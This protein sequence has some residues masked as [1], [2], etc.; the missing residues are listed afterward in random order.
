MNSRRTDYTKEEGK[1]IDRSGL[2]EIGKPSEG[3]NEGRT[4]LEGLTGRR[5]NGQGEANG[6]PQQQNSPEGLGLRQR[7]VGGK[8]ENRNSIN[9]EEG[10]EEGQEDI[11][12]VEDFDQMGD[13]TQ[14]G[15]KGLDWSDF[16]VDFHS[17][18]PSI[19]AKE[20]QRVAKNNATKLI[21][22]RPYMIPRPFT[23][24]E[25]DSIQKCLDLFRLMN[26]RHMPVLA[27]E[28]GSLVGMISRQDLFAFMTL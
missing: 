25:N 16:N 21:D 8:N 6:G 20:L 18:T 15:Q 22:L 19:H 12:E 28:D 9:N 13:L 1:D 11:E 4:S 5:E 14:A 7:N 10:E 24:F 3:D 17:S 26:L 23:V 2:N 27:E